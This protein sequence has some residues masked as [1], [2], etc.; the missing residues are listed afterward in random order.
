MWKIHFHIYVMKNYLYSKSNR[1]MLVMIFEPVL[2]DY[3][4]FFDSQDYQLPLFLRIFDIF[5]QNYMIK[6][7][8]FFK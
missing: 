7:I 4:L 2:R 3:R 6:V 5:L 1:S 8:Y